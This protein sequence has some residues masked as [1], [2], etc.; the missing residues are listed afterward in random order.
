[1]T[2]RDVTHEKRI[3]VGRALATKQNRRQ[4]D[5]LSFKPRPAGGGGETVPL[6]LFSGI[7]KTEMNRATKLSEPISKF[8]EN[9]EKFPLVCTS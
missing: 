8:F 6:C 9:F 3:R 2:E 7:A 5:R 1:M 4:V